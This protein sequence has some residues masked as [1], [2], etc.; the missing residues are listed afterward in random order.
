[1]TKYVTIEGTDGA[2]KTTLFEGLLKYLTLNNRLSVLDTKE[3]GS[4]HDQA[5]VNLRNIILNSEMKMTSLAMQLGFASIVAQHQ[6]QV[7]GPARASGKYDYI[8]SDRGIDSNYAYAEGH[9]LD[10]QDIQS[11]FNTVYRLFNAPE[12]TIF[13][14]IHPDLA[15][16][17]IKSRGGE[18]FEGGGV[19]AVEAKGLELQHIARGKYLQRSYETDRIKV[20]DVTPEKTPDDILLETLLIL[21]EIPNEAAKKIKI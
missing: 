15:F 1:M 9:G 5:C 7:I 19:D 8:L 2:G 20:I 12:I 21:G 18:T 11:I 14:N 13:L 3:F 4:R 10:P 17:R 16:K 6:E